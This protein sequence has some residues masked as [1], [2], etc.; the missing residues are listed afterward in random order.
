VI[1]G[2]V[3][4]GIRAWPLPVRFAR[5]VANLHRRFVSA[6]FNPMAESIVATA[7]RQPSLAIFSP[8]GA[9]EVRTVGPH[10]S[11]AFYIA[12][13]PDGQQF[14]TYGL[15][16]I[17][18]L[19]SASTMTQSTL[20]QTH[21][22]SISQVAFTAG[23]G[24]LIT[25]GRDGNLIRWTSTGAPHVV[26]RFSQPVSAFALAPAARLAVVGTADGAL[27]R[28]TEDGQIASLRTGRATPL[29]MRAMPDGCTF[30]IGYADGE[31]IVVDTRSGL[32]SRLIQATDAIQHTLAQLYRFH[33]LGI[34]VAGV[35]RI[36]AGL[37]VLEEHAR[38]LAPGDPPQVLDAH[39][40][41]H[42]DPIAFRGVG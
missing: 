16:D 28:V 32:Q 10:H 6:V 23:T 41:L 30:F 40:V 4:G 17:V 18:E 15:G 12:A 36:G 38:H 42:G 31:V 13:A 19:W 24:E 20:R 39:C 35:F 5:V 11:E 37:Q 9:G 34:G 26:A 29:I 27:W 3:R 14:A 2:D 7:H 21:H 8:T 25:A 22:G 1:S 33:V